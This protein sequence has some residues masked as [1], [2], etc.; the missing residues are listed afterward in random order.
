RVLE[1]GPDL[2]VL[3]IHL[4][5]LDGLE[6]LRHITQVQ[7]V[8]AVALTGDRDPELVRRAL[9]DNIL[10]YLLKPVDARQL[11]AAVQVAWARFQEFCALRSE[12]E[13]LH[14]A[15]QDR[16]L[17]EKAKGV[18]MQRHGWSEEAAFARLRGAAMDRRARLVQVA[19]EVLDGGDLR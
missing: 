8:A 5:D 18:L 7:P 15:L 10:A 14:Q 4:P 11:R 12:N 19:R 16:K 6:A 13:S 9:E 3:D 2:L 1:H 17:I